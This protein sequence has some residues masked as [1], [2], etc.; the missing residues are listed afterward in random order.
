MKIKHDVRYLNIVDTVKITFMILLCEI[1]QPSG[2]NHAMCNTL[3]Y[4]KSKNHAG[5]GKCL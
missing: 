4:K 1:L 5:G 2:N 3:T